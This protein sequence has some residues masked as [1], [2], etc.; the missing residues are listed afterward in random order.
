MEILLAEARHLK[1]V[2]HWD[3]LERIALDVGVAKPAVG[4]RLVHRLAVER[5]ETAA[6]TD[7]DR[8]GQ[9]LPGTGS[10][11]SMVCLCHLLDAVTPASAIDRLAFQNYPGHQRLDF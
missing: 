1:V 11:T 4:V 10:T 2:R 7:E 8:H 5:R 6:A 3:R 9:Q